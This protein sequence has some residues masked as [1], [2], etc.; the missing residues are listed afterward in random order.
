[1]GC[2]NLFGIMPLKQEYESRN[3]DLCMTH[4]KSPFSV[5]NVHFTPNQS[6][7]RIVCLT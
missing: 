5:P 2:E 6:G 1:M 7:E 4:P 3:V